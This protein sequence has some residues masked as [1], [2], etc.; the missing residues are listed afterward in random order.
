MTMLYTLGGFVFV[1]GLMMLVASLFGANLYTY[2]WIA[3][4]GGFVLGLLG[5]GLRW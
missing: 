2:A 5:K 3:L 1:A 4:A